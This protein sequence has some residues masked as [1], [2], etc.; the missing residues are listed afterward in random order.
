MQPAARLALSR[1]GQVVCAVRVDRVDRVARR[2]QI[3]LVRDAWRGVWGATCVTVSPGR[4]SRWYGGGG[5]GG[6]D[7]LAVVAKARSRCRR[8]PT[9][10]TRVVTYRFRCRKPWSAT[11]EAGAALSL[12]STTQPGRSQRV[13]HQTDTTAH[14]TIVGPGSVVNREVRCEHHTG[15]E[16]VG[17]VARHLLV[18]RK[19]SPLE[20]AGVHRRLRYCTVVPPRPAGR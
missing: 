15:K 3:V 2:Q 13:A 17:A 1:D 7:R 10:I 5:G 4:S 20:G 12:A 6:G 8:R 14:P 11:G 18:P 9:P 19:H 16:L